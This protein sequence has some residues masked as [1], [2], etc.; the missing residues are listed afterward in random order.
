[1]TTPQIHPTAHV[2]I[3][4]ADYPVT[5]DTI[6]LDESWA[7]YCQA[8]LFAPFNDASS[9]VNIDP[10]K[11]PRATIMV[12]GDVNGA[13]RTFDLGIRS[14]DVDYRSKV[15]RLTL[16]SDEALLQDFAPL[17]DDGT[18]RS[19]ETSLRAVVN[20]VLTKSIPGAALNAIFND[21]FETD[22]LGWTPASAE[23][24]ISASTAAPRSGARHLLAYRT[25]SA[26]QFQVGRVIS[27]LVVGRS[28]TAQA[29]V[30]AG[31]NAITAA[32]VVVPGVASG[33][34]V[35]LTTTSPYTRVFVTFT[36][37]AT[38]H[39]VQ[40]QGTTAG[41]GANYAARWDD[42][43]VIDNTE[44]TADAD[45]TAYWAV[46]NKLS[47]PG[48]ETDL[49]GWMTGFGATS[50]QRV[51]NSGSP[52]GGAWAI[53]WLANAA[54]SAL[55]AS[56]TTGAFS[57]NPGTS[58]VFTIYSYGGGA[59][60]ASARLQFYAADG[61]VLISEVAGASQ[62]LNTDGTYKRFTVIA[63]AP[64]GAETM[65]GILY[66]ENSVANE[67]YLADGAMLYEGNEVI[68]Y[69]DGNT[70]D[71]PQYDYAWS[72][73]ANASPSSRTPT[74][75]R[76]PDAL[77][78]KAGV[79]GWDFLEPLLSQAGLRLFCDE[80]RV[81]RLVLAYSLPQVIPLTPSLSVDATDVI[82]REDDTPWADG[83]VVRYVWDDREL[84]A[85]VRVDSAG[86]A[87]KTL[88]VTYDR[89]YPG[90]GA[91]AN[92]LQASTGRGRVQNVDALIDYATTPG[93]ETFIPTDAGQLSGRVRA[94]QF[95]LTAGTM[96]VGSKDQAELSSDMIDA[97]PGVI[98][99][100]PDTIDN[101][102]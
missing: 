47:N 70:A 87:G 44:P 80:K 66:I 43:A 5:G 61:T 29:W 72:G 71:T 14:R 18:P 32:S 9:V 25:N 8:D 49:K 68:P 64:A 97:L 40:L 6:A 2:T 93:M 91:A 3:G 16:A 7:P 96:S 39:T 100:L 12:A 48:V 94:V 75:N 86:S 89:P 78:W 73:T 51:S 82:T 37:T 13:S 63:T 69:F 57:C 58:Y 99:N 10:R 67:G 26:G 60:T 17:A 35:N 1:M 23:T 42:V 95:D 90:P 56:P 83:V 15:V 4:G 52:A 85:Q 50:M 101:L 45:T 20:Y 30:R 76:P 84:G 81:W 92:I 33:A 41:V 36:A 53:L 54:T 74:V 59:R 55:V 88:V 27:G 24:T 62:V 65:Q 77:I 38:S 79:S 28:Y 22:P 102:P 46:T 19:Y 34:T 98:D 21:S 31:S 11:T